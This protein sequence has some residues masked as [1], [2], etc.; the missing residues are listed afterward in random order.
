MRVRAALLVALSALLGCEETPA[1]PPPAL[2]E[3]TQTHPSQRPPI[4]DID[5]DNLL[6][7]A[8]GASVVSR[9]AEQNLENSAAHAI[10]GIS[11]TSWRSPPGSA[12]E[13]FI[14][15][16]PTRAAVT[17]VGVTTSEFEEIPTAVRFE[18]SLDGMTW[19]DVTTV[20]LESNAGPQMKSVPRFEARYL[21]L[22][23]VA[24]A[25]TV[26][27]RVRS[28]HAIGT[29]LERPKTRS[30][31]GCW[32]INGFAAQFAQ[33]GA[34]VTGVIETDPPTVLEGGFDGRVAMMMWMQGPMWGYAPITLSPDAAHLTGMKFYE[35]LDTHHAGEGWFGERCDDRSAGGP[36]VRMP[37]IR[38]LDRAKRYSAFGLAF[39][40]NDRLILDL[41]ASA[42]D[43]IASLNPSRI[44]AYEQREDTPEKNLAHTKARL[45]S[46]RAALQSRGVDVHRLE[47]IAKGSE[48]NGPPISCALQRLMTSRVDIIRAP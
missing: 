21:R 25:G 19:R 1:P 15:S 16:L 12:Q 4:P 46:L 42:L 41:S 2:P 7:M 32:T 35:E 34:H 45:Q 30:V 6:N 23:T 33:N 36:A 26:F 9:T 24:P 48:W 20:A 29:E 13:T 8:F 5:E 28:F 22:H 37:A 14:L 11:L 43:V 40:A 17:R 38:W 47:L 31:G 39:D 44:V 3:I 10:D 18:A 27:A